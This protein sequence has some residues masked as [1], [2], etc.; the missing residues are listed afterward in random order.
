MNFFVH[1]VKLTMLTHLQV[2]DAH[3]GPVRGAGLLFG[4]LP[5][6]PQPRQQAAPH[7]ALARV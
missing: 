7:V 1:K 2:P 6:R 5:P 3:A 4:L